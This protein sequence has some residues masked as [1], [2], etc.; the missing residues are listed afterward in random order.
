MC[1]WCHFAARMGHG[2]HFKG[3]KWHPLSEIGKISA[4]MLEIWRR[5]GIGYRPLCTN[6]PDSK[7]H[8]AH[9]GPTWLLLAPWTLLSGI[10]IK[11]CPCISEQ[12]VKKVCHG[13][14]QL[15][16]PLA[17]WRSGR[18]YQTVIFKFTSWI[19]FWSNWYIND[20]ARMW[21]NPHHVPM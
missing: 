1:V 17:Y 16:N 9:M 12:R 6:I 3:R 21:H 5:Q 18:N 13:C 11:L 2:L 4:W 14:R 8:V 10:I 20:P 7:V 15:V 19:C